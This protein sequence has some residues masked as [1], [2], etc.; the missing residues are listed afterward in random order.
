MLRDL[1]NYRWGVVGFGVYIYWVIV[2]FV[3][4]LEMFKVEIESD[5]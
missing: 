5:I 4:W 1:L 2:V 3:V